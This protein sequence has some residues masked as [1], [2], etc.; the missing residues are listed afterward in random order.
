MYAE[1]GAFADRIARAN[2]RGRAT[3]HLADPTAERVWPSLL[4]EEGSQAVVDEHFID[5][6]VLELADLL[7]FTVAPER[8]EAFT[9]R[10]E[11]F[12]PRFRRGLRRELEAAGIALPPEGLGR[13]LP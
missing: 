4:A 7:L 3:L 2:L 11:D 6:D 1:L 13:T 10:F 9:F 12:G 5:R 8:P